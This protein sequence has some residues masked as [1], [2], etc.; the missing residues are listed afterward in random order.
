MTGWLVGVDAGGTNTR[1]LALDPATGETR[2]AREEG[3]NWTV[4]GPD[5]CRERLARAV[6]GVIPAGDRPAAICLSIAGYY[7]PDHAAQ[8]EPWAAAAWPGFARVVPDVTAAWAGAHAGEP[9]IVV[10]SGT[11]SIA[12][13]RN[14]QGEEHRA[15]G[16]G[17]LFGDEGSAYWVG[18]AC[19]R[20]LAMEVD[21]A[22]QRTPLAEW[23]LRRWPELGGD[24]RAW[25]R[26]VYRHGWGREE[27]AAVAGEAAVLADQ[28]DPGTTGIL[29][30]AAIELAGMVLLVQQRLGSQS[31]LPVALT[32]GLA[33]GS[34]V[35]REEFAEAI[36]PFGA[37]LRLT[38]PRF[39]PL[40]GAL[41]LAAEACDP[42]SVEQVR[43]ALRSSQDV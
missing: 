35:L 18:V 36:S 23:V 11:G 38:P 5:L 16:W 14:A 24:L 15:G 41:L 21:M 32:G 26:G 3:S 31:Q 7:P 27:V 10:I 17:P 9:G 12:Y 28:G 6:G 40:Q 33:A 29:A 2:E 37:C 42:G 20:R 43:A 30:S 34:R 13:G 1:A 25:L 39:S 8:A 4:H 22:A 19:L